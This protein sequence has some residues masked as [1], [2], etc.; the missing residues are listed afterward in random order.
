MLE[1][2]DAAF[3]EHAAGALGLDEVDLALRQT[4]QVSAI[5]AAR[6][7]SDAGAIA[8]QPAIGDRT[9]RRHWCTTDSRS[10][11]S[12]RRVLSRIPGPAPGISHA[13]IALEGQGSVP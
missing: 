7:L 4:Q 8:T 1:V 3:T 9:T 10:A 13:S 5:G 2:D 12:L 6:S 11:Y